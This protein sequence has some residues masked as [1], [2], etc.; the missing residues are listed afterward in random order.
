MSY[1]KPAVT[2][3]VYPFHQVEIEDYWDG[4]YGGW[5]AILAEFLGT[6]MYVF[7]SAGLAIAVNT[8][9]FYNSSIVFPII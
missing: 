2:R 7:V 5:R 4:V 8:Y 9:P 3:L 1:A 6:M